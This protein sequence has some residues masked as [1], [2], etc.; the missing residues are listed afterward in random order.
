MQAIYPATGL[1]SGKKLRFDAVPLQGR[2]YLVQG[3]VG[4]V[5]FVG[6]AVDEQDLY[7]LLS[8]G[9]T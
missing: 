7:A 5:V 4:A 3:G 6:A 8:N 2:F 9:F 1:L